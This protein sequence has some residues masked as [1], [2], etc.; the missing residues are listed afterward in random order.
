MNVDKIILWIINES[1]SIH[2]YID[3]ISDSECL[4][5]LMTTI[6]TTTFRLIK[7]HDS[8]YISIVTYLLIVIP[9]KKNS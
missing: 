6:F 8:V 2:L 5:E 3:P 1:E 7:P 4:W 9:L